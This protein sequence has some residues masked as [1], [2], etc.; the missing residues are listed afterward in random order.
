MLINFTFDLTSEWFLF[1]V[2]LCVLKIKHKKIRANWGGTKRWQE[3]RWSYFGAVEAWQGCIPHQRVW[4]TTCVDTFVVF[5]IQATRLQA[6][7]AADQAQLLR[8]R[9][10]SSLLKDYEF[11]ALAIETLVCWSADMKSFVKGL[12]SRLIDA[13]TQEVAYLSKQIGLAVQRGDAASIKGT[14]CNQI[15]M[16]CYFYNFRDAI[17]F[18]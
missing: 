5:H 17:Y 2:Y 3:S 11:A 7:A 6:G 4:D 15:Q 10:Y 14:G 12:S 13:S 9:K 18:A 1:I 8:H 16:E